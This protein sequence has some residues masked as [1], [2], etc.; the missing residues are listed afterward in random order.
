L[1]PLIGICSNYD[2]D[3]KEYCLSDFY[4]DA[5]YRAGASAVLL[6]P[7]EDL[8][9]L[10]PY[11]QICNGYV[12]PGGGDV[13]PF[14]WGELP[15]WGLGEINPR[16]DY[17]ELKLAELVMDRR[18]PV[19]GICRG[20]QILNVAA[21]GSLMQDISSPLKHQQEAPREYPFHD[22]TIKPGTLLAKILDKAEIRVNSFH[23]QAI[24]RPGRGMRISAL[25]PDGIIEAVESAEAPFI[26]GVQWHPEC[27]RDKA[28]DQLFRALVQ[29]AQTAGN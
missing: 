8:N 15:Q 13:D 9:L 2:M 16:R 29:A 25:A 17:F 23:H 21:R 14:H 12:F 18:L 4:V 11:L 5:L 6:P 3:I 24:E 22:I 28:S 1:R 20:C 10:E 26:L 7:I 27:M 19:L